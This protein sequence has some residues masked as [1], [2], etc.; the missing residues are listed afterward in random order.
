MARKTRPIPPPPT[1][2]TSSKCPIRSPGITRPSRIRDS[3]VG[4]GRR[5][6]RRRT[7]DDRRIVG[8]R[9]ADPTRGRR[10]AVGAHRRALAR[11]MATV[12]AFERWKRN[13]SSGCCRETDAA[14]RPRFKRDQGRHCCT[15]MWYEPPDPWDERPTRK[16]LQYPRN[17]ILTA[18]RKKR[19]FGGS[20]GGVASGRVRM[21][22]TELCRIAL[23]TRHPPHLFEE[24][25]SGDIA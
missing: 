24:G 4:G 25:L 15:S 16:V 13:R 3:R 23:A 9:L 20:I 12:R 10:R 18:W 14:T 7:G 1:Y 22:S 11:A 21:S 6:D 2:S 8:R 17:S 5:R 19:Q